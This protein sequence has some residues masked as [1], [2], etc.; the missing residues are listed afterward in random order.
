VFAV[1]SVYACLKNGRHLVAYEAD[2]QIFNAILAPLR[3]LSAQH[4][5]VQTPTQ[6]MVM[7]DDEKPVRKVARKIR[8]ST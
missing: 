8:L 6:S 3:A 1:A 2:Y 4:S 5:R 7:E